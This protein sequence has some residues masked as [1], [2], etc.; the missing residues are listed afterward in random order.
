MSFSSLYIGILAATTA[1]P[2][3][4]TINIGFSSL[5]IGILAATGTPTRF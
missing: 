5:Y 4:E 3:T 2:S 1:E